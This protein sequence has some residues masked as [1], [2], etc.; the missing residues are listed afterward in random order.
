VQ[1]DADGRIYLLLLPIAEDETPHYMREVLEKL[2]VPLAIKRRDK[3]VQQIEAVKGAIIA[4]GDEDAAAP[5]QVSKRPRIIITFDGERE[6]LDAS[7][8]LLVDY[9]PADF[10]DQ[11]IEIVKFAA[12]CSKIQQPNDVSP[13]FMVLK[14]SAKLGVQAPAPKYLTQLLDKVLAPLEGSSKNTYMEFLQHITTHVSKA[15]TAGNISKGWAISGNYPLDHN[16]IMRRCTTWKQLSEKQAKAIESALPELVEQAAHLGELDDEAMQ[17]AVGSAIDLEAW[18]REKSGIDRKKGKDLKDMVTNR[19]RVIWL[20]H[21]GVT[22]RRMQRLV[23]EAER[24]EQKRREKEE[25]EAKRAQEAREREERKIAKEQ[26]RVA[27]ELENAERLKKRKIRE[28]Q[29]E[30]KRR[31]QEGRAEE[32]RKR[33]KLPARYAKDYT[34]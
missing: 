32:R 21:E 17:A 34:A 27:R 7:M 23:D 22:E 33:Q 31:K 11:G 8:D 12:A 10:K 6:H 19:R 30:A 14:Q 15:F 2:V 3:L 16:V 29:R 26:R 25:R 24:E 4:D 18:L 20:N 9:P 1:L 5:A 13:A 28:E